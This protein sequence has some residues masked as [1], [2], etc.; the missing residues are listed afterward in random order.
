MAI[1]TS[2]LEEIWFFVSLAENENAHGAAKSAISV[3]LNRLNNRLV[4]V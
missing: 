4:C 2:I 3:T 1:Q